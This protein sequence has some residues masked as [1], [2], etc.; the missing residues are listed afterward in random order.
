MRFLLFCLILLP[1]LVN[2]QLRR[3]DSIGNVI[4]TRNDA[5]FSGVDGMLRIAQRRG[6]VHVG[7]V[8]ATGPT[9][10]MQMRMVDS[11]NIR[12]A[13]SSEM[14]IH[15][16]STGA[17]QPVNIAM[18]YRH[19]GLLLVSGR[20]ERESFTLNT[21]FADVDI[22]NGVFEIEQETTASYLLGVY[23]GSIRIFN[24]P[25]GLQV[26]DINAESF[27]RIT[28]NGTI[29]TIDRNTLQAQRD[30]NCAPLGVN[31]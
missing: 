27:V 1:L 15:E 11:G 3:A 21:P 16:Y 6:E 26:G 5:V 20:S 13:C 10:P 30:R 22:R 24:N 4:T 14:V 25:G 12:L 7:D 9:T 29:E 19:G 23:Q 28:L 17:D 31:Q 18:E 2:A 8:I